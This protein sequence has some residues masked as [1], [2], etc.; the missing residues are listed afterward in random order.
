M[1]KIYQL[2]FTIYNLKGFIFIMSFIDSLKALAWS[3]R[4]PLDDLLAPQRVQFK[5]KS[6]FF[7]I[8]VE[9]NGPNH[10]LLCG[11]IV[12][13][14]NTGKEV[15]SYEFSIIPQ[16]KGKPATIKWLKSQ[17]VEL[18]GETIS[19]YENAIK[20]AEAPKVAMEKATNWCMQTLVDN[21]CNTGYLVCFPSAF[22]GRFWT[23]YCERYN[24]NGYANFK[25]FFPKARA[26]ADEE[27][28]RDPFGFNH[29]DGQTF[30]MAQLKLPSRL[31]L[32][33]LR[34]KCFDAKELE[35]FNKVAHDAV[36]DARNQG[37]LF[38]RLANMDLV[39]LKQ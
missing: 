39:E 14:D 13:F 33:K 15:D 22:D 12:A 18:E 21:K 32:K 16:T 9:T 34:L 28:Y 27:N 30:A 29:I 19:A 24:L 6:M 38:F 1:I 4:I 3:A 25:S 23:N 26:D 2:N 37:E 35:S 36:S 7:S 5:E 31:P 11:G 20:N 10:D 8:D 17:M